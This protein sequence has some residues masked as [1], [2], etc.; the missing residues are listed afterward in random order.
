MTF[1]AERE[2]EVVALNYDNLFGVQ[3]EKREYYIFFGN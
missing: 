2:R 1:L 3:R